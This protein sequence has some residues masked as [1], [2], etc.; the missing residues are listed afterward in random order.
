MSTRPV[1]AALLALA[2]TVVAAPAAQAATRLT[3]TAAGTAAERVAERYADATNADDHGVDS[4]TRRS[5]TAFSCDLFVSVTVDDATQRECAATVT[6]RLGRHRPARPTVG[7]AVWT[8]EDQTV[9][10]DD[11]EGA[12]DVPA[13]DDAGGD[14]EL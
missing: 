2:L 6:V 4:C 7:K 10:G 3:S 5:R 8:C 1:R 12:D 13:D 9:A 14:E 11:D